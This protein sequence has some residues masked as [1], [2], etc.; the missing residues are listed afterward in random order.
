MRFSFG[1]AQAELYKA[2]QLFIGINM[3]DL[4][5]EIFECRSLLCIEML[6]ENA[7]PS[8]AG[9]NKVLLES[10]ANARRLD[11]IR[12]LAAD[13][14][15]MEKEAADIRAFLAKKAAQPE[16]KPKLLLCD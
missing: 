6:I 1:I 10:M 3:K 7:L 9:A 13:A 14:L 15:G 12:V 5:K 16:A 4:L 2:G 8:A 11:D